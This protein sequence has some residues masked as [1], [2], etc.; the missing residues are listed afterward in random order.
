MYN[1]IHFMKNVKFNFQEAQTEAKAVVLLHNEI[2]FYYAGFWVKY[3]CPYDKEIF[4]QLVAFRE[5]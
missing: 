5:R 1:F 2:A 4:A 3:R